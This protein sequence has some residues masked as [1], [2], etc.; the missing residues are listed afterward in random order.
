MWRSC[1][2]CSA[3]LKAVATSTSSLVEGRKFSAVDGPQ[4]AQRS[5]KVGCIPANMRKRLVRL[6]IG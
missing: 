3:I 1:D 2:I 6:Y 5:T 4:K